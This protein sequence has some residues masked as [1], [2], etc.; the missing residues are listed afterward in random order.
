MRGAGGAT[1]F[2]RSRAGF[3]TPSAKRCLIRVLDRWCW[4]RGGASDERDQ[5]SR[6]NNLAMWKGL[7]WLMSRG[8]TSL[9]FGRTSCSQEGLR[10]YKRGWGAAESTLHYHKLALPSTTW[11]R[12]RDRAAGLHTRVFSHLPLFLNR[13]LGAALYPHLD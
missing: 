6:A 2:L 1:A 4:P 7:Q 9:H 13:L 10:R 11:V 5:A 3:S 12:D 8:V